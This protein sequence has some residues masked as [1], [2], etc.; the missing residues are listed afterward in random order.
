[1]AHFLFS[2]PFRQSWTAIKYKINFEY[3]LRHSIR[4]RPLVLRLP[5]IY[6]QRLRPISYFKV[7]AAFPYFLQ[8]YKLIIRVKL[9]YVT[10]LSPGYTVQHCAQYCAQHP[11]LDVATRSQHSVQHYA[12]YFGFL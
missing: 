6:L 3:N 10:T 12:Q 5:T 7:K 4:S 9:R 11:S 2:S 8:R 1:M